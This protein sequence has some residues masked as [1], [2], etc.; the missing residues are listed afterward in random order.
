MNNIIA[1]AIKE[2]KQAFKEYE[3]VLEES[4]IA[5]KNIED[6]LNYLTKESD[7]LKINNFT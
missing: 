1:T 3:S 5:L 2:A 7:K 6:S 4:E